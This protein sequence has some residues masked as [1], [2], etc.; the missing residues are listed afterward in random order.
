MFFFF[1]RFLDPDPQ[2]LVGDLESSSN[3]RFKKLNKALAQLVRV[4]RC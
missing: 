4:Q 3:K 1:V 2:D